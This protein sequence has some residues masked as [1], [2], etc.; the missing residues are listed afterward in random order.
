MWSESSESTRLRVFIRSFESKEFVVPKMPNKYP[1]SLDFMAN[2]P[3]CPSL[4]FKDLLD[5]K[6]RRAAHMSSIPFVLL[7][8]VNDHCTAI[9]GHG[10]WDLSWRTSGISSPGF[11]SANSWAK[12][13]GRSAKIIQDPFLLPRWNMLW[14]S[15]KKPKG[16]LEVF[17]KIAASFEGTSTFHILGETLHGAFNP[18]AK[19]TIFLQF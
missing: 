1:N 6:P 15:E 13:S 12:I 5:L 14:R 2:V 4:Q 7:S 17:G 10:D 8:D 3:P 11:F 9:Q 19:W 18:T 16:V